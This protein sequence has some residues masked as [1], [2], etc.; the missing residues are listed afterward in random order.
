MKTYA[1]CGWHH[2]G[3][4][5]EGW[6][7]QDMCGLLGPSLALGKR[8]F[9]DEYGPESGLVAI[10][11]LLLE[12]FA[13]HPWFDYEIPYNVRQRAVDLWIREKSG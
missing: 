13:K 11:D 6:S 9:C 1:S 10:Q 8:T 7:R 4:Q 5:E 2:L 3:I 12:A